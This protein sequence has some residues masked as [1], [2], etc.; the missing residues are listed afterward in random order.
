MARQ[1]SALLLTWSHF[2]KAEGRENTGETEIGIGASFATIRVF[3][4]SDN[5]RHYFLKATKVG[6]VGGREQNEV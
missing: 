2:S 4:Y 3:K 1:A 5:A 6:K